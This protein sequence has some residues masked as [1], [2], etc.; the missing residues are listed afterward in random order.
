MAGKLDRNGNEMIE[1]QECGRWYHTLAVHLKSRHG[2]DV[3]TYKAK[4][5]GAPTISLFGSNQI[6]MAQKGKQL[7]NLNGNA[8]K[9]ENGAN[10]ITLE[11]TVSPAVANGLALTFGAAELSLRPDNGLDEI[12][13]KHIP[14]HDPNFDLDPAVTEMLALGIEQGDNVLMVGPTGCGKTATVKELAALLNQPVKRVNLHG[15]IRASDFVGEKVVEIATSTNQAIVSWKDGVL[16]DAMRRG[17]WLLLDEIDAATPQILFVLQSVLDSGQLVLTANHG[18]VVEP[19]ENFRIISTANTTGH[20]D[21]TG[22]YVGTNTLN[23]AFLDRFGTVIFQDYIPQT[24]EAMII[25]RKANVGL[26]VAKKLVEV[27]KYVRNGLI[28]EECHCTLS[29]RRL[30]MW[31]NKIGKLGVHK[32]AQVAVLNKL[33]KED[34]T[35]V[36]AIVQ[37]IFGY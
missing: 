24:Q 7:N 23:E 13:K 34:E 16:P 17:Y 22:L 6:S 5:L 4:H 18:E 37:R 21:D 28:H 32:A 31:A 9:P 2:M 8:D 29:T 33:S 15:D 14:N 36:K 20:G 3:H 26:D 30:I 19:H 35:Y 1:C 12:D 10:V 25:H 11:P 27:A